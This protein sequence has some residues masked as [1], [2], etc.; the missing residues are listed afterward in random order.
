MSRAL[1]IR[2]DVPN[3]AARTVALPQGL[4]YIATEAERAGHHC[5]IVDTVVEPDWRKRVSECAGCGYDLV[6]ISC[7]SGTSLGVALQVGHTQACV[8]R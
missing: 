2:C 8:P 7:L 3:R 4:L 1:L 5:T 6:G